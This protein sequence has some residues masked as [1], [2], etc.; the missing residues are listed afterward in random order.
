M[1]VSQRPGQGSPA[2][3]TSWSQ[4][5][6]YFDGDGNVGLEVL[7]RVLRFK[8]RFV[9]TWKPQ[10]DSIATFLAQQGINCGCVGKGD[11]RGTWQAAYR[12]DIVEVGSVLE[13]AKSMLV[14]TVKKRT[15]LQAVIDYLEGGG[16]AMRSWKSS[17]RPSKSVGGEAKSGMKTYHSPGRKGFGYLNWRTPATQELHTR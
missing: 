14:G 3:Y 2:A 12:L 8:I 9:D 6:G 1:G 10:I 7:K 5:S 13:T 15:E 4:L 17:T 11:K 16:Q